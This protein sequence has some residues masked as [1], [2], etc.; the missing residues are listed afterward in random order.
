MIEVAIKMDS[1]NDFKLIDCIEKGEYDLVSN[2]E[3][4]FKDLIIRILNAYNYQINAVYI[5]SEFCQHQIPDLEYV[6]SF[7]QECVHRNLKLTLLTPPVTDYGINKLKRLF[8]GLIE[9]NLSVEFNDVGVLEL[10]QDYTFPKK[11]GRIFDKMPHD[12]RVSKEQLEMFYENKGMDYICSLAIQSNSFQTILRRYNVTDFDID[13]SMQGINIDK[14]PNQRIGIFFPYGYLTTGR[15]CE[16]KLNEQERKDRYDILKPCVK[17]YCD[18]VDVVMTKQL[19]NCP[20]AYKATS[21]RIQLFKKG[22]TIF[23][24]YNTEQYNISSYANVSRIILMPKIS[25]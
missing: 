15:V 11:C 25:I 17:K 4:P 21:R 22:N 20:D 24:P 2:T 19:N 7:Y 18:S 14:I 6:L 5:G 1:F 9:C 3:Y 13:I 10:L 23:Y 16:L 8:Q 12:I